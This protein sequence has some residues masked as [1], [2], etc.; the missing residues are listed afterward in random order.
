[1]SS[2]S[3][4][5]ALATAKPKIS[6]K[7]RV[8][9]NAKKAGDWGKLYDES[10]DPAKSLKR[11]FSDKDEWRFELR[12]LHDEG[13]LHFAED[14]DEIVVPLLAAASTDVNA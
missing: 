10:I 12:Q 14:R 13:N 9:L 2:A 4:R 7:I 8:V 11:K 6:I 1:M 5:G 3:D